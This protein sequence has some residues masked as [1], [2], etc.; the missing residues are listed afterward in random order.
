ML[1]TQLL[2]A[3]QAI[4]TEKYIACGSKY[5]ITIY[6]M[7]EHPYITQGPY[8][9]N[10]FV[11]DAEKSLDFSDVWIPMT[12]NQLIEYLEQGIDSFLSSQVHEYWAEQIKYAT[13]CEV[14]ESRKL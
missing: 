1:R 14:I 8:L 4:A 2:M 9:V 3:K 7:L 5:E 12:H 13:Y 10:E 11:Q 6:V